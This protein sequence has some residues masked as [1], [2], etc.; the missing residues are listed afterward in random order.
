[1]QVMLPPSSDLLRL[2]KLTLHLFLN[3]FPEEV[4][5]Y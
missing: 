4:K 5:K 1:M 2:Y 3:R